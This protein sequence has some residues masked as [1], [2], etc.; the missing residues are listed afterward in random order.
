VLDTLNDVLGAHIF[1]AREDGAAP[2]ACPSCSNGQLSLKLGKFG[3]FI[4]CSNY[5]ECK[6]TRTLTAPNGEVPIGE[7]AERPGV[8]VLGIDPISKEDVSLRDGRFGPY[9]QL[10]EAEK[11]KRSSLPRGVSAADIDLDKALYLLSMPREIARHPETSEPI[12]VSIGRFGPYVQ[13]AKTYAS[14]TR[15]DDIFSIG[16]NRAIDLIITKEQGGGRKNFG[17]ST[18]RVIG[19]HPDG[20]AISVKSGRFGAYVNHGKINATIPKGTDPDSISLA[21]AIEMIKARAA[22]APS[23]G[24]I[25]GE[26]PQGGVIAVREGRYGPYVSHGK[27]NATLPKSMTPEQVTLADAIE[28]I[29]EKGGPDKKLTAKKGAK[30]ASPKATTSKAASK[31]ATSQKATSQKATSAT[32]KAPAAKKPRAKTA[33]KKPA[34]KKS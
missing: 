2:R 8:R 28:L 17:A 13:H 33:A 19:D 23:D 10:G 27:V 16:E 12:V 7:D 22:G 15:D 4:G 6:F 21:D 5:P 11:P 25:L 20:G 31:K 24:R 1:P 9:V 26:H 3:A 34:R 14:L 29:D 30:K 32:T 18:G